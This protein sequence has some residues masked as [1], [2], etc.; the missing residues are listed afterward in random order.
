MGVQDGGRILRLTFGCS[1]DATFRNGARATEG[2]FL[3]RLC[4]TATNGRRRRGSARRGKPRIPFDDAVARALARASHLRQR[5]NAFRWSGVLAVAA[6]VGGCASAPTA[7]LGESRAALRTAEE[8]GAGNHP[9]AAYHLELAEE[10]IAA[11]EDLMDGNH[12]ERKM[13]RRHLQRAALDAE[14]AIAYTKTADAEERAKEAWHEVAELTEAR[15]A[16]ED[17]GV[18]AARRP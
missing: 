4:G 10:Q 12:R 18:P 3:S 16:D 14:L 7:Q 11:A 9:D 15:D 13:A 6:L 5:V 8:L 2:S 1:N 17:D